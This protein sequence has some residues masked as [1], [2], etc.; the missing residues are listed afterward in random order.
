MAALLDLSNE[1]ILDIGSY[2][3]PTP[4][5]SLPGRP[6][7]Q[8]TLTLK[9]HNDIAFKISQDLIALIKCCRQLRELLTS[10]LYEYLPL[11]SSYVRT[12][13]A[14]RTLKENRSLCVY[15]K[16]ISLNVTKP[17]TNTSTRSNRKST[18]RPAFKAQEDFRSIFSWLPHVHTID[19]NGYAGDDAEPL[20]QE[21]DDEP[22]LAHRSV[23]PVQVLRLA[24]C[25]VHENLLREVVSFPASLKELWYE[26]DTYHWSTD[27]ELDPDGTFTCAAIQD[28]VAFQKDSL[29]KLVISRIN[30]NDER[31]ASLDGISLV[32]CKR[33]KS[34]SVYCGY[35]LC[36]ELQGGPSVTCLPSSLEELE[37]CYDGSDNVG[38]LYMV[39]NGNRQWLYDLVKQPSDGTHGERPRFTPKLK[40]I[41]VISLEWYP[42]DDDLEH[43]LTDTDESDHDDGVDSPILDT[44]RLHSNRDSPWQ[45]P[46]Y[47]LR[48]LTTSV[49]HNLSWSIYLH[50][51]RRC[52]YT[53]A[54]GTGFADSWEDLWD[55]YQ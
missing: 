2:I 23:S 31:F 44:A 34:L 41:R 40:R 11:F 20:F 36:T 3:K 5:T 54:G 27:N 25:G 49:L 48:W 21:E 51:D 28:A 10:L 24:N 37:V 9:Q 8:W 1:L 6:F 45:P 39:D 42:G 4:P 22:E 13:L 29:E 17:Y 47:M 12:D 30:G 52:A 7:D 46:K 19:I 26:H 16:H 53:P 35:L 38:F 50:P 14:L 33:L 43:D 32:G 55:G 15:V 18:R